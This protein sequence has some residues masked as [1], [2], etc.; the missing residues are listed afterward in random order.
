MAGKKRSR[1]SR[2]RKD[3]LTGGSGDVKPQVLTVTTGTPAAINDYTV[4]Q[5]VLP[6]TRM[7][8]NRKLAMVFE[9]L[10]IDW[11]LG[12]EDAA[13][14]AHTNIGFLATVTNR[15]TGDTTTLASMAVDVTDPLV[16][17]PAIA[18]RSTAVGW[19]DIAPIH[20]DMTDNRGNGVLVA[21][22]RLFIVGGNVGATA[23]GRATAKITY[24]QSNVGVFEYVGIVQSQ[25][26]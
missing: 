21:T 14:A 9:I 19:G 3:T 24:R 25:Q 8:T 18:H 26:G 2:P 10:S 13:D 20:I 16:I 15:T 5:I 12:I 6:V 1:S 11:Y 17:G 22:D 4:K 7:S 23:V